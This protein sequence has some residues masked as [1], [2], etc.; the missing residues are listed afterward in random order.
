MRIGLRER[1]DDELCRRFRIGHYRN[2][3]LLYRIAARDEHMRK[4]VKMALTFVDFAIIVDSS[5][6]D[7]P[8]RPAA[9]TAEGRVLDRDS[10]LS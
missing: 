8:L 9:S 5:E 3:V 6:I 4:N 10:R 1:R 2:D 7:R